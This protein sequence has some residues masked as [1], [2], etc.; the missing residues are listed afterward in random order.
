[1]LCLHHLILRHSA[2]SDAILT[3]HDSGSSYNFNGH[4]YPARQ[5]GRKNFERR[6]ENQFRKSADTHDVQLQNANR[7]YA[8]LQRHLSYLLR[9]ELPQYLRIFSDSEY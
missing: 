8:S 7:Q 4:T 6:K 3:S 2:F 1:M 9:Q 5:G